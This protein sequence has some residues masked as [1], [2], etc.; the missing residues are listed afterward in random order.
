MRWLALVAVFLLAVGCSSTTSP[1]ADVVVVYCAQDQVYGEP[2]LDEFEKKTGIKVNWKFDVESAK[3]TGL[4]NRIAAE[5][6]NPQC[7]VFWNN[8]VAQTISLQRQGLLEAYRSPS[9]EGIPAE[10]LDP[11]GYWTGIAARARILLY[12]T[13]RVKREDA[14]RSIL[15][16]THPKWK[17]KVA[18]ARP[19]FGT[20]LT[21]AAALFQVLGEERARAFFE[22]LKANEVLLAEGNAHAKDMVASGEAWVCVT[23]TD[24]ANVALRD[25]KPVAVV[26]PD[27]DGM[28]TF[29]IPNT[30][31][32]IKGA[33]H[34]DN[35]K[36]LV[37]YLCGREV[38]E[39]L[40]H[41]DSA[42]L[43]LHAGL[44][45]PPAMPGL[46]R[47]KPMKV[48]YEDLGARMKQ[49]TDYLRD[50]FLR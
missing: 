42:Q 16:L 39:K 40:A 29:M 4:V 15:D 50:Q 46:G 19:L 17:G 10:F 14:P 27:Q 1:G 25:K 5:K 18:Y 28:G 41:S 30:V 36:K 22:G 12:N 32:M 7:D 6:A 37:D 11:D 24:D 2:I 8:E 43:P 38:E 35:A 45:P 33:P 3:T 20:T 26:F 13:D 47:I 21:Q 49:I 34:P 44:P 31:M 9:R 23:D 48:D